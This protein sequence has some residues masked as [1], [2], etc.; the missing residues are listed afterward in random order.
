MFRLID[1]EPA[2]L[3]PIEEV[4]VLVVLGD[5]RHPQAADM[6][7]QFRAARIGQFF[8]TVTS[9]RTR[10]IVPLAD[11]RAVLDAASRLGAL[12][13]EIVE[14]GAI[15]EVH[16]LLAAPLARR[17][18]EVAAAAALAATEAEGNA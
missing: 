16:A 10:I 18:Q 6:I 7:Q 9:R 17:A 5:R 11:E 15:V 12:P 8:M 2:D 4:D 14:P 13:D 3:P 1:S